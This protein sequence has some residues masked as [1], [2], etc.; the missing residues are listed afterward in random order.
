MS[1]ADWWRARRAEQL[2]RESL[3]EPTEVV[4]SRLNRIEARLKAIGVRVDHLE[5]DGEEQKRA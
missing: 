5:G 2:Q 3:P 4:N 1:L